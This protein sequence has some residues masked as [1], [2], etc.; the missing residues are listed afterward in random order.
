MKSIHKKTGFTLAEVLIASTIGGFVT[1][2]LFSGAITMQR[3]FV[4][5][6][7]LMS[8]TAEQTRLSDYLAMDLRR[9]FT[10]TKGTDGTTV[11]TMTMADYYDADGLPRTP[12]IVKQAINYGDNS[13]PM[14]VTYKKIGS[15][16]YRQERSNA[17]VKIASDVDDFQIDIP[18]NAGQVVETTVSFVP[19]F[20]YNASANATALRAANTLHSTV[21]LRNKRT[22][23]K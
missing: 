3:S 1:L 18:D 21:V 15:E 7:D 10:I 16:V 13:N 11:A 9:A 14:T 23:K 19:T 17:P 12:T 2:V 22:D 5:G 8:A 20:Q 6:E 4:A